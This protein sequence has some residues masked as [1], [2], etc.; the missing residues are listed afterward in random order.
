MAKK[1]GFYRIANEATASMIEANHNKK[2]A[3]PINSVGLYN[4]LSY[5]SNC[6]GNEEG[7]FY[8]KRAEILKDLSISKSA[9]YSARDPLITNGYLET[10]E[11]YLIIDGKRSDHQ[12][13][14]FRIIK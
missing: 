7:V 10:W 12:Y 9:Y 14:F 4:Y 2:K 3:M 11:D 6:Y 1:K 5:L 8:R 13:T